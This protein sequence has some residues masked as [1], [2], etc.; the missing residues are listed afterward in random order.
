[1][2]LRACQC[3]LAETSLVALLALAVLSPHD[4]P[5]A[6][7]PAKVDFVKE[8][9][10][11]LKARCHECHGPDMREAGLRLD[12][13]ALALAGGD[14]GP[15]IVPGEPG[16]SLL[17]E[18][19]RG[20]DPDRLMPPKDATLTKNEIALLERWIKEGATWPEGVDE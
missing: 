17:L 7:P 15:V 3:E 13:K 18:L 4:M 11:I 9:R 12:E 20:E 8:V 19:V 16:E 1:L 10:P 5:A 2:S 14:S 6:D